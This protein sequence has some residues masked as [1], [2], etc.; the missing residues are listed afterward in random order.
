MTNPP[1]T[2]GGATAGLLRRI[3]REPLSVF[4]LISAAIFAID[5]WFA[6]YSDSLNAAVEGPRPAP[7][8]AGPIIVTNALVDDLRENYRWLHGRDP[9]QAE[10][11]LLIQGWIADEV[12]FR[13]GLAQRMH[14]TDAKV[15]ALIIDK[16]RLLWSTTPEEPGEADLLGYYVDNIGRYYSEPRVSFEQV[17]FQKAR[18]DGA[19]VLDALR[20]GEMVAGDG[21]WLGDR[22]ENYSQSIL[23]NNLGMPFYDA[24][25]ELPQQQWHGP[26]ASTRGQ[27]F[28]R[29]LAVQP[30]APLP[31][32]EVRTRVERD[33][34]ESQRA[35]GIAEQTMAIMAGH[36]IVL[37]LAE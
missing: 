17:F 14:L 1:S 9:D 7:E 13:E 15:R 16:V 30:A 10:T 27:H 34:L 20:S 23:R 31:Y 6:D 12:V 28:V 21:F 36:R 26:L 8:H 35:A 25:V 37:D 33:W 22:L 18:A 11:D 5:A 2:G 32:E 24:L 3:V 29:V 4:V 19:S